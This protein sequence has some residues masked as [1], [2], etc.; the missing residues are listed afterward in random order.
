[1]LKYGH[2]CLFYVCFC[3]EK[4]IFDR[5]EWNLGSSDYIMWEHQYP[6]VFRTGLL[7][8]Y[9]IMPTYAHA[10]VYAMSAHVCAYV[11]I[12]KL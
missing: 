4:E 6:I 7:Y 11:Q 5:D 10:H 12:R 3:I 8:V 2:C 1:M 9:Y